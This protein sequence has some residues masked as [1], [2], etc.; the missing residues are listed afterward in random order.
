MSKC[1]FC[2]RPVSVCPSV[3]LVNSILTAEYVAK[4]LLPTGTR[5]TVAFMTPGADTNSK[6]N[7]DTGGAKYTGWGKLAFF[8]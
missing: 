5:T 8:D 6:D 2:C 1:G 4:L 7:A 3:T